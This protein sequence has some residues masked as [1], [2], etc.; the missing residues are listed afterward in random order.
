MRRLEKKSNSGREKNVLLQRKL[1]MRVVSTIQD[2]TV[3]YNEL[4]ITFLDIDSDSD[5]EG[6]VPEKKEEE[7]ELDVCMYV[8]MYLC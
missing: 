4:I 8:C 5:K 3:L 1:R 7:E 6:K 2:S